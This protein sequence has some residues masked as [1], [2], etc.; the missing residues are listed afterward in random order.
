M[1]TQCVTGLRRTRLIKQTY[2]AIMGCFKMTMIVSFV[3]NSL[4]FTTLTSKS[5]TVVKHSDI[6][7]SN[8]IFHD[9]K[10]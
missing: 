3:L 7:N 5:Y 1:S 10:L 9:H 8:Y 4:F 6:I 2:H